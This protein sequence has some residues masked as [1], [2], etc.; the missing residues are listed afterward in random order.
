MIWGGVSLS[1]SLSTSLNG[2]LV[3]NAKLVDIPATVLWDDFHIYSFI[4]S[5]VL[6]MILAYCCSRLSRKHSTTH[7]P[8]KISFLLGWFL[9]R[10]LRMLMNGKW[11]R[12]AKILWKI[13]SL[14]DLRD[15]TVTGYFKTSSWSLI[16]YL[17]YYYFYHY[18]YTIFV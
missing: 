17:K 11:Y 6:C 8:G 10:F 14:L 3:I 13:V 1:G 12:P 18:Y 5:N 4:Q 9:H 15:A 2:V 7:L 16:G